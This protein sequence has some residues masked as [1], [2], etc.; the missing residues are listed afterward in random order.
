[1]P[2]SHHISAQKLFIE[3]LEKYKELLDEDSKKQTNINE[4]LRHD[5]DEVLIVNKHLE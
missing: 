3:K 2:Q 5:N 1:M 4:T